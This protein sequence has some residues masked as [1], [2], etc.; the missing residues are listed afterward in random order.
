MA[1]ENKDELPA[2]FERRVSPKL[3]ELFLRACEVTA[4]LFEAHNNL[5]GYE[6]LRMF[7]QRTIHETFPK[8]SMQEV[9]LLTSA[10]AGYHRARLENRPRE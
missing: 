9:A 5:G 4:T 10:V 2:G 3:R 6:N 7:A 8:L 1:E